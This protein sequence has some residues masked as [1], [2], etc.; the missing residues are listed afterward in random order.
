MDKGDRTGIVEV[1]YDDTRCAWVASS[2]GTN[3][4]P[5]EAASVTSFIDCIHPTRQAEGS[6]E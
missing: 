3:H 1:R 6:N 2:F 4:D 5:S